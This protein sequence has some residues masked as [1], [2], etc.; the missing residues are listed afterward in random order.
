M[1]ANCCPT[2]RLLASSLERTCAYCGDDVIAPALLA[3]PR[4]AGVTALAKR[5]PTGWRD[6][7][8]LYGTAF[9]VLGGVVTGF[10][11]ADTPGILLGPLIG[12]LGYTKQFW[13]SAFTRR[14]KDM[15]IAP[16]RPPT[17]E[18]ILGVAQPHQRTVELAN[19]PPRTLAVAS[20]V[21]LDGGIIAR[22]IASV[23]FWLV[24][25]DQRRILVDGSSWL[26]SSK[27]E[28]LS[29]ITANK[30]LHD[31][32]VTLT[33]AQRSRITLTRTVLVAGDR[34]SAIGAIAPEQLPGAGYRDHLVDARTFWRTAVARAPRSRRSRSEL[35]GAPRDW[36]CRPFHSL[37]H[38]FGT[39]CARR[40]VPVMPLRD[41]MGHEGRE[42]D[43]ALRHGDVRRQADRH[44]ASVRAACVPRSP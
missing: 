8:A 18:R 29:A 40:G 38:S 22:Q 9:G 23:P 28:R 3:R 2:C 6:R 26:T 11:L 15:P 37:R 19:V 32:R 7:L 31:A 12:L 44:H 43:A 14:D 41:L 21:L 17:G 27:P 13:R 10:V 33:R 35:T 5:P 4:I 24:R 36:P 42:D 30:V 16:L 1:T 25:A 20:T 34:F 39:E